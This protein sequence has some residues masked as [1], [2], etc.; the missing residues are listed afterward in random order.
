MID[1]VTN[2]PVGPAAVSPPRDV[3]APAYPQLLRTPWH[4][5]WRPLLG[6]LFATVVLVATGIAVV[7]AAMIARAV[8][9]GSL[10]VSPDSLSPD[11]PL[12]LLANDL[13]IAGLI[14]AAVLAVLV[15]HRSPV[16]RLFSVVGRVRWR[17]L[18]VCSGIAVV[19]VLVFYGLSIFVDV[20]GSDTS[21]PGAATVVGLL[22]V[23]AVS[24]PLQSAGEEVGFRGYLSQA[25]A[26]WFSRPVVGTVAAGLA[27]AGLFALAHG[28]QDP[29]LFA[30]RFCFGLTS[31]WLVWRTGG[32]EASVALHA[33][34]NLV[35]LGVTAVTS[36]I[37]DSL[38]SSTLDWRSALIDV[39]MMIGYAVAVDRFAKRRALDRVATPLPDRDSRRSALSRSSGVGYPDP[40][41]STPSPTGEE[42]PW[43]MG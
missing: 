36:S 25:V 40:R 2:P 26:S 29:W 3:A 13:V 35:S 39:A 14:P 30:D 6:V 32:L 4:R 38:T 9:E 1:G 31:S 7:L 17:W 43:G 16:G 24:T 21:A 22:L 15:V 28:G 8:Q 42:P 5:W 19:F 20:P 10:D 18:L 41:S 37:Q 33:V 11:T 12:G 34:N 23:I 27:S